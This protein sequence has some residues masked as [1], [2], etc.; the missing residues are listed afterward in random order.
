MSDCAFFPI[1]EKDKLKLTR[2]LMKVGKKWN[3]RMER[4]QPL[5]LDNNNITGTH[6]YVNET[7]QVVR[8]EANPQMKANMLRKSA[9]NFFINQKDAEDFRDGILEALRCILARPEDIPEE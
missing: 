7:L 5:Y 1:E 9:G 3:E 4:I 6:W 8:K 2:A